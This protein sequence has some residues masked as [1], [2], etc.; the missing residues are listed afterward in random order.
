MPISTLLNTND[1]DDWKT[2]FN[3]V[4]A[5]INTMG[6]VASLS[7]TDKTSLVNAINELVAKM[8][9]LAS[10]STT[11]KTSLVNAINELAVSVNGLVIGTSVQAFSPLLTSLAGLS[12]LV[13]DRIAYTTGTNTFSAA[14]ITT[15]GRNVIAAANA[16]AI[17]T[18]LQLGPLSTITAFSADTI[19]AAI[20]ADT[21]IEISCTALGRALIASTSTQSAI[22]TL[23]L[24]QTVNSKKLYFAERFI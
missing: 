9:S 6:A 23:G 13:A 1:F 16:G 15:T 11:N 17:R 24:T 2:L 3:Q 14:T 4:V 21:P 18:I 22:N 8:G 10:L 20:T 19:I 5:Q 12:T 7:T